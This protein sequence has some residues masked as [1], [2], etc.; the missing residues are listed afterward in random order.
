M[1]FRLSLLCAGALLAVAVGAGAQTPQI[2]RFGQP[3]AANYAGK[4]SD[5]AQLKA[6]AR[7]ESKAAPFAPQFRANRYG[8]LTASGAALKLKRTGFFHVERRGQRWLLVDPGGDAF[9]HLGV[10]VMSPGDEY[11]VVAGREKTFAWIP[12]R[13][14]EFASA[15]LDG[16]PDA[17]SFHLANTIRKYGA[18]Y[19]L[20]TNSAR[21]IKR[22]RDYG[23]NSGGAFSPATQS[24]RK[25]N[26]PF[27]AHLA[28]DLPQLPG[29]SGVW[30]PF[31][32]E[33]APKLDAAF[34][35][36]VAPDAKDPLL[37]GYFVSN[38]PLFEDVPK[39]VP[40]LDG[41]HACKREL[42]AMLRLKY[43]VIAAFNDAWK[44]DF[45]SFDALEGAS[46]PVQTP[47]A[48]GDMGAFN[49][50]FLERY[51][52][53]VTRTFRRYDSHHMLIGNR[54]QAG[55][56][57]NEAL[58]RLSGKYLD[59]ISFNYYTYALDTD[60]LKRIHKWSGGRPMMLTEF[61]WSAPSQSG[62]GASQAVGTQRERGLA[63]RNYV[64]GAAALGFVVGTEWFTL[65]DQSATGRWF[66]GLNGENNNTG[67]W[68]VADRPW[69]AALDE[70]S[71]TNGDIYRV[72]LGQ[73][74]PF[75]FADGRFNG[76]S[77]A[78]K[79]LA[80]MRATGAITLDGTAKNFPGLPA[81]TISSRRLIQGASA[82]GLEASFK[83][84]WD[85]QFLYLLA[86][87]K[88]PTPMRNTQSGSGLWNGDG[89]ELFFGWEKLGEGGPL[90]FSDRQVLLGAG[91]NNQTFFANAPAQSEC[92]S[93]VV[94]GADGKSYTLEAAIPW[95]ALGATPRVGQEFRFDLA[96]DD[97]ASGWRERQL[98]WNGGPKNSS[99]RTHWGR[100]KLAP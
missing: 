43:R 55:T 19:D 87:V 61:Y 89:L 71:R 91:Q 39:V 2:D 48:S 26:F 69:S 98:M 74:A 84:C 50:R 54:L 49:E 17:F 57:N 77:D 27:V 21:V 96:V 25:A 37:I 32:A 7:A 66:Q 100:L 18:P 22:L 33:N 12:P 41:T 82:Q 73:R 14:G 93:V 65:V 29:V 11:T 88:D 44:T 59:V 70:M 85:D 81:E 76:Q 90:L 64:E 42:V 83:T 47:V 46:L 95:S 86:D 92:K 30:D 5:E 10:C 58:C 67:L 52:Q 4:V 60:L 8:G 24:E 35:K 51:F 36:Y 6:D 78:P 15:Y 16:H 56:I 53:L 63:Y 80:S 99:D 9:F 13:Q 62:L 40:T 3:A 94:P 79:T 68:S 31:D 72:W 45:A 38:E 28:I 34:A 23:F 1:N 97:A 20:E 75:R